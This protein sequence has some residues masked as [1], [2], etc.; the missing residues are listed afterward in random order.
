[1]GE[2]LGR[3]GGD[4]GRWVGAVVGNLRWSWSRDQY[5]SLT[6]KNDA[7]DLLLLLPGWVWNLVSLG[8]TGVHPAG[9]VWL[10]PHL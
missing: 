9:R 10:V 7:Q 4:G 2:E 5:S 3:H 6:A 8:M 1:M